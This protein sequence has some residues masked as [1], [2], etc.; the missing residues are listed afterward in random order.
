MRRK[1]RGFGFD[2]EQ[3]TNPPVLLK[4]ETNAPL[5]VA[6][7]YRKIMMSIA[8]VYKL[9]V[10][11][12]ETTDPFLVNE[13]ISNRIKQIPIDNSSLRFRSYRIHVDNK[14][15]QEM[16]VYTDHIET[17][18]DDGVTWTPAFHLFDSLML[19]KLGMN[20][21][22]HIVM[23]LEQLRAET[24]DKHRPVQVVCFEDETRISTTGSLDDL[25]RTFTHKRDKTLINIQTY[26]SFAL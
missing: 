4:L 23:Q 7:A 1:E 17:L 22:V 15:C 18:A 26:G 19:F 13:F 9:T 24:D 25:D 10:K 21:S 16:G 20:K 3:L 2:T 8:G 12:F 6:N 11:Y 5:Y 14:I